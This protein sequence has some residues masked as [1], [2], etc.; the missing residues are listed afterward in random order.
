MSKP[1]Q[2]LFEAPSTSVP[3]SFTNPYAHPEFYNLESEVPEFLGELGSKK[4]ASRRVRRFTCSNAEKAKL[5]NFLQMSI[6]VE[7]LRS[8]IDDASGRA[9]SATLKAA[10]ALETVPRSVKTKQL[11]CEAFGVAPEFVPPW[12]PTKARWKDLGGLVAIRLRD[13]AKIV[14]GG[15][16]RYFCWGSSTHCPECPDSPPTYFACSSFKGTYIICLGQ[17][18]WKAWQDRDTTTMASTLL[19]E[20]LHIYFGRTVADKRFSGN[21]NCY[22]R[23]V[24]RFNRLFLHSATDS[25]CPA[26]NCAGVV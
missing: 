11:F 4:N 18:F 16:I 2:W 21:A 3:S 8:A 7:A 13:A 26:K 15:W 25:N 9:V 10:V 23:F 22:E 5:E 12:R 14:D 24:V 20:A 19:H 1:T 17:G 6:P